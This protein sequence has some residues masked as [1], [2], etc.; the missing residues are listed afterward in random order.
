MGAAAAAGAG[1]S[2]AAGS[3]QPYDTVTSIARRFGF[4]SLM[5]F[6]RDVIQAFG[7]HPSECMRLGR[8]RI[9]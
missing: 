1:A 4:N 7:S 3:P 2:G 9:L 6:S 5:V 8:N